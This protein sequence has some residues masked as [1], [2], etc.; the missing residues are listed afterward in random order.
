LTS[1]KTRSERELIST[2]AGMVNR[3]RSHV[4][5]RE[6]VQGLRERGRCHL[7]GHR[8]TLVTEGRRAG[9]RGSKWLGRTKGDYPSCLFLPSRRV[10]KV[11]PRLADLYL[12]AEVVKPQ[13]VPLLAVENVRD[14]RVD[15]SPQRLVGLHGEAIVLETYRA[16]Q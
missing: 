8:R 7:P 12:V 2:V 10:T 16:R 4:R 5:V 3:R 9:R 14:R 6:R 13:S 11:S 1:E 15:G